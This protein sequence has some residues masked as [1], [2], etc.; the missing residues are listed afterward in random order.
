[1]VGTRSQAA[2]GGCEGV[3]QLRVPQGLRFGQCDVVEADPELEPDRFEGHERH[4]VVPLEVHEQVRQ[5]ERSR[6]EPGEPHRRR[7]SELHGVEL[8]GPR[9]ERPTGEPPIA[10]EGPTEIALDLDELELQSGRFMR[11]LKERGGFI[12]VDKSL[13]LGLPELRVVPDREKAAAVG[14]DAAALATTVQ[15][16]IGGLDVGTFKDGGRRYDIRVS[17]EDEERSE[18]SAIERLYV[19]G[20]DGEVFELRNLVRVE[21]GAAPSAITR[22][23]RERSVTIWANLS[24][25]SLSEAIR[26]AFAVGE[27]T[28]PPN[29]RLALSGEAEAFGEMVGQ[30]LSM[31]FLSVLVVYMVLAAQFESLLH[32]FTVMLALPFAMVG[33]LGGLYATGMTLNVFSII[34]IILL[35]GLV[36]KNSILLVDYANQLRS[37]GAE[38]VAAMRRAAAVRM[39]PVLM[40]SVS[41]IF[42]VLPAALGVGPGAENRQPMGVATAAGMFSSTLLTLVVVPVFY[43]MLDDARDLFRRRIGPLRR[44]RGEP[45]SPAVGS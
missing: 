43:L 24:G 10:S 8:D 39:R 44:S 34:G 31:L 38:K 30:T 21:A 25:I 14:V 15:A 1:M 41:M 16:M 36:T 4:L 11:V 33:A 20:R 45:S 3:T 6:H 13:E 40:T 18:P 22:R 27:E 2:H 28:L 5:G 12:E 35:L 17:L 32:P 9:V 29:L 42:G 7:Q 26:E 19:P 37:E 23:N